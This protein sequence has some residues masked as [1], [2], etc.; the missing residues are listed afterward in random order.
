[1]VSIRCLGGL[2]T[3]RFCSQGNIRLRVELVVIEGKGAY[4]RSGFKGGTDLIAPAWHQG[5]Q[6]QYPVR[7]EPNRGQVGSK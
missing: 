7:G 6:D 1:M 4:Q 5:Y 2:I 3:A